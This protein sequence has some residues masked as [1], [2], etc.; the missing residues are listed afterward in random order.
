M[1]GGSVAVYLYGCDATISNSILVSGNGGDGGSGGNGGQGG[2]GGSGGWGG[3]AAVPDA[4]NPYGASQETGS[5]GGRGGNGG[6]GGNGGHGG[7]G[8][9]GPSIGL[10]IGGGSTPTL[11]DN[12][13]TTGYGGNSG[14]SAGNPGSDGLVADIYP[15]PLTALAL[16]IA[17]SGIDALLSW[18][19]QPDNYVSYEILY[20]LAPYFLPDD[21]DVVV[22]I[23]AAPDNWTHIGTTGDADNNY[24]YLLRGVTSEGDKSPE[25]NKKCEFTFA[26]ENGVTGEYGDW[27]L[28]R[29]IPFV[30]P[31]AA[32]Y[33]P[34]NGLI[35]VGRRDTASDGLYR[36]ESDDSATL[37]AGGSNIAAVAV[38][39]QTGHIF[40]SEDFDGVI[41]RSEITGTGRTTWVSGFHSGDDDPVGMAFAPD[42]YS[43][44]VISPGDG[45]VID[46]GS[47]GPDEVWRF[48]PDVAEGESVVHSDDGTLVDSVDIAVGLN[49]IYLV[50]DKD[51]GDGVIY[52]LNAD[53][54][55]TEIPTT[56][57]LP[58]PEGIT[59]DPLTGNLL[60]VDVVNAK[61]YD[62]N[63]VT[64][65]AVDMLPGFVFDF[66]GG[67]SWAGIDISPDGQQLIISDKGPDVI[68]VFTRA[69]S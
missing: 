11:A 15:I 39:H 7:G 22:A 44:S 50:D 13:I 37:I 25:S 21:L 60:V 29:T 62:I 31:Q 23:P 67:S 35:Y 52:R 53:G 58:A 33:N 49:N 69:N 45:L 34:V 63:P 17:V 26:L 48:S 41:Y 8:A 20:S 16:D 66:P 24:C 68:Y 3:D 59:I 10:Y 57:L 64:G 65:V 38:D 28:S 30:N 12:T 32:H 9:G 43:G 54:S 2:A 19:D 61:V 18:L 27:N 56:T 51:A 5:N 14:S 55:L 47:G 36:I 1:D 46:R 4:G 6:G 42:A 40:A